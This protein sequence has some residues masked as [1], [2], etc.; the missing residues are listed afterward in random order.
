M[1]VAVPTCVG[2]DDSWEGREEEEKFLLVCSDKAGG[3][4]R[5]GSGVSLSG[6]DSD[7]GGVC[8]ALFLPEARER[9]SFHSAHE[10]T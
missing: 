4:R 8:E 7:C 2:D 5:G 9:P 6:D 1:V 3:W 10:V